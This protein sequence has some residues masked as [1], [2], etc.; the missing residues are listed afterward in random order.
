MGWGGGGGWDGGGGEWDGGG[1]VVGWWGVVGS[2]MV[3][4]G[5]TGHWSRRTVE[6]FL[7]FVFRVEMSIGLTAYPLNYYFFKFC[8]KM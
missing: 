3:V 8:L 7:F 4:V 6:P 5:K 2:G 1:G